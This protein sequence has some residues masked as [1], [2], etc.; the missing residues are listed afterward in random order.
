MNL[1]YLFVVYFMTLSVLS[2]ES[3]ATVE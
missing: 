1:S 3:Q 2:V